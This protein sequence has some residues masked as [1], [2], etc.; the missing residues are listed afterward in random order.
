MIKPIAPTDPDFEK[1]RAGECPKCGRMSPTYGLPEVDGDECSQEAMCE[2]GFHWWEVYAIDRVDIEEKEPAPPPVRD[3]KAILRE[4]LDHA[5][6]SCI[7]TEL[8]IEAREVVRH[9]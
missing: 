4:M 6:P 8:M 7:P 1:M 5:D 2:C 9:G 3:A